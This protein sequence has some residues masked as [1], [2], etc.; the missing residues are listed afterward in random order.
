MSLTL[1]YARKLDV[2]EDTVIKGEKEED[3]GR[4]G[5]LIVF[6]QIAATKITVVQK[7]IYL[8]RVKFK[9]LTRVCILLKWNAFINLR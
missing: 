6:F 3:D 1:Q 8:Y 5:V 4:E 2:N 7:V 9:M